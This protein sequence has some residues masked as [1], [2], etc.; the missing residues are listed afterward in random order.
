MKTLQLYRKVGAEMVVTITMH[1]DSQF[2][3]GTEH[4]GFVDI[5][6][7]AIEHMLQDSHWTVED[8]KKIEIE[9]D[10]TSSTNWLLHDL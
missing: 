1:D 2:V 6:K 9:V 10:Y 8:I 5:T 4:E 7:Y 3:E